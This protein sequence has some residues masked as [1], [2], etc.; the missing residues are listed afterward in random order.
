MNSTPA[1][2]LFAIVGAVI[3][4][5]AMKFLFGGS[6]DASLDRIGEELTQT[7]ALYRVMEEEYPEDFGVLL[8]E[9]KDIRELPEPEQAAREA[10][11]AHATE[12]RLRESGNALAAED[13]LLTAYLERSADTLDVVLRELGE[14]R[15]GQYGTLGAAALGPAASDPAILPVIDAQVAALFRV[16]ANG[17]D[18]EPRALPSQ[19]DYAA[20]NDPAGLSEEEASRFQLVGSQAAGTDGYCRALAWYLRRLARSEAEGAD[21]VRAGI[22]QSLAQG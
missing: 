13:R 12:L 7:S 11:F 4:F 6:G 8:R 3:G 21:R 22:A 1:R 16:L 5:F 15:C 17:R 18:R 14:T 19:E 10:A 2:L 20:V 9:L